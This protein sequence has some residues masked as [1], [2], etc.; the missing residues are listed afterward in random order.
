MN[1]F[2]AVFKRELKGYFA[3]PVAYVFLVIFLFFAGYLTF[4]NGFFELRQA[5]MR[6][7]FYKSAAALCLYGSLHGNEALVR[8]TQG[9]LYRASSY[10]AHHGKPGGSRQILRSLVLPCY[11]IAAH[12]PGAYYCL[13]SWQP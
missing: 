12:D 10:T 4:K 6:S 1:G 5:D 2:K 13:L 3:T 8:R 7:F 9:W 11:C